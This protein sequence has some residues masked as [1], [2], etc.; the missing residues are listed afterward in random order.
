M[1]TKN[2]D[3]SVEKPTFRDYIGWIGIAPVVMLLAALGIVAGIVIGGGNY[4][5]G[6]SVS[7]IVLFGGTILFMGLKSYYDQ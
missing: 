4:Q 1:T 2:T 5:L 7:I 6:V 3:D